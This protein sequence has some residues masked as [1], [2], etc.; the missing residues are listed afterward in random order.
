MARLYERLDRSASR[1]IRVLGNFVQIYCR[2]NHR[3]VPKDIFPVPDDRL[4]RSLGG[5]DL[6]LCTECRKLLQHGIAKRL[7]C[8]YD[9][10]PRCKKCPTHCY[11][12]GYREAMRR[13]MR[14]SGMYLVRHGR[15]DLIVHYLF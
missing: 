4:R 14:F 9:P 5:R 11:S 7:Q 10:R 3:D 1:D 6:S 15:L 8:P 12:P 13:V 2:E